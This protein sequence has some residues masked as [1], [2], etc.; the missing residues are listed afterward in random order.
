MSD[1]V[2]LAEKLLLAA[3][4]LFFIACAGFLSSLYI[5]DPLIQ[6]WTGGL[7]V[8]PAITVIPWLII[9]AASSVFSRQS[10]RMCWL[11]MTVPPAL[12]TTWLFLTFGYSCFVLRDCL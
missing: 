6:W 1:P 3:G 8:V 5:S 2:N 7:A 4:A 12:F 11:L 9:A 10:I